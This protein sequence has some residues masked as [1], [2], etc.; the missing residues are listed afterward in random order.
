MYTI[1]QLDVNP[2]HLQNFHE[3]FTLTRPLPVYRQLIR[4]EKKILTFTDIIFLLY[5]RLLLTTFKK[6]YPK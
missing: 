6:I 4:Q 2:I 3:R 1:L 5:K